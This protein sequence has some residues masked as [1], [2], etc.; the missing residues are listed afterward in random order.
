M[1][2]DELRGCIWRA[3]MIAEAKGPRHAYWDMISDA[4]AIL[5]GER[6]VRSRVAIERIIC[7]CGLDR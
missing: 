7:E 6:S 3:R 1:T 5:K 2:D 4:E